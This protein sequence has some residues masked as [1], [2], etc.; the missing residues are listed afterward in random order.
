MLEIVGNLLRIGGWLGNSIELQMAH[1]DVNPWIDLDIPEPISGGAA[2]RGDDNGSA[3]ALEDK[4][5][6]PGTT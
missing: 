3:A 2:G 1:S 4:W 5:G 6:N